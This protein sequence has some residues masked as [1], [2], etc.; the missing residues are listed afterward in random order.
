DL[1]DIETSG[2]D[3]GFDKIIDVG[4]LQFEGT[5]LIRT[6]ESL[7]RFDGELPHMIQKL[8]GITPAMLK[9]APQWRD[10]EPEVMDLY[11]HDL[12]AHNADFEKSFLGEHF[13][14]IANKD[15]ARERWQDSLYYLAILFPERSTFKLESFITEWKLADKEE[16]RG[17]SD[18]RDLL[19]VL[20]LATLHARKEPERFSALMGHARRL[21][22]DQEWFY[23]FFQLDIIDLKDIALA[24]DFDLEGAYQNAF[25]ATA[26]PTSNEFT[27]RYNFSFDSEKIKEIY[28][29]EERM[30]E[31]F[32]GYRYRPAQEELSLKVGQCFKN[33]VH[34]LVQAP[35][36]TGK[37]VGYLLPAT[38]FSLAEKKQVLVSTGTKT[39]QH[40]C[41]SKDVPQLRKILGLDEERLKIKRLVGSNNHL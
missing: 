33:N 37:T 21:N 39:L 25:L 29:A 41:M 23:R 13:D 28:R 26:I 18:S 20:L 34:A 9:R 38:L 17:L 15:D 3:A 10:V 5:K 1:I 19:K 11:G 2:I 8:T 35:T 14:H 6:Y 40:Q 7:V 32:P 36:G 16:H 12:V 31:I 30:Q 27:P 22:F 24:I 4:F